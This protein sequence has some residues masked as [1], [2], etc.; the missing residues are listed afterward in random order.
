MHC[1]THLRRPDKSSGGTSGGTARRSLD[2]RY[3]R[4]GR[5]VDV[6]SLR[7]TMPR[8]PKYNRPTRLNQSEAEKDAEI[9]GIRDYFKLPRHRCALPNC[10]VH[11]NYTHTELQYGT[12]SLRFRFAS[13]SREREREENAF[14]AFCGVL[15][16]LC[17][18]V[19]VCFVCVLFERRGKQLRAKGVAE[20]TGCR[21]ATGRD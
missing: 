11:R 16:V 21:R 3:V 2:V 13:L 12:L 9:Q 8:Q 1:T 19:F 10:I 6:R 17:C 5:S 15:F 20:V 4:F 14:V 18:F 7:S